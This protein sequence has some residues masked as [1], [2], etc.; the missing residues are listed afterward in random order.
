M[1]EVYKSI[2]C[3]TAAMGAVFLAGQV[4]EYSHAEFGL[5]ENLLASCFYVLTGFHG[6]PRLNRSFINS[7]LYYG[8][9]AKR[10]TILLVVTLVSKLP[11][12]TGTLS[13]LFGWCYL[14]W[15]T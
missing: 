2:L 15:Y 10:D 4:Y 12:F 14:F 13:M 1:L 6:L 8:D 11:R 9:R 7:L 5:T 3:I